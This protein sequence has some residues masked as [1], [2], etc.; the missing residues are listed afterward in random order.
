MLERQEQGPDVH[1]E[2]T[3]KVVG[4]IANVGSKHIRKVPTREWVVSV[5]QGPLVGV[6][7]STVTELAISFVIGSQSRNVRVRDCVVLSGLAERKQNTIFT[8]SSLADTMLR[9]L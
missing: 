8:E 7:D 3:V 1:I 2:F 9:L 4:S 6:V 5:D